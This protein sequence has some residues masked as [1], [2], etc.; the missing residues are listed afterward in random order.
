M[1]PYWFVF[2]LDETL[3]H[4]NPYFC[5]ICSFFLRDIAINAGRPNLAKNVPASLGDRVQEAYD[6]FVQRCAEAELSGEP[7][8]IL[9]PGIVNLFRKIGQLKDAGV[10]GGA[11]IYSNNGTKRVLQFVADV[12]H[13]AVGRNDLICDNVHL[14]DARRGPEVR[15]R[16]KQIA[17]ILSILQSAPCSASVVPTADDIFFFDDTIHPDIRAA[18]GDKYIQVS[19]YSY[20]VDAGKMG[21]I[22]IQC[23]R[24][25]GILDGANLQRDFFGHMGKSC[26]FEKIFPFSTEEDLEREI[27]RQFKQLQ[28]LPYQPPVED[29]SLDD[30][31]ARLDNMLAPVAPNNLGNNPL[32]AIQNNAL[33]GGRKRK[34][35]QT[36]KRARKNRRNTRTKWQRR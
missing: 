6:L 3:T 20:Q 10:A 18:I 12:L 28:P 31:L 26:F 19:P 8:G 33:T 5:L 29:E 1:P 27:R 24:D 32:S 21:D 36:K 9:R 2:D 23:L 16:V 35:K 34:F 11:F 7:L 30:I 4:M 15:S 14:R 22:Y 17:T 25:V 13:S